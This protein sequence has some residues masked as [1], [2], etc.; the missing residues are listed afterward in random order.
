MGRTPDR[1]QLSNA[2]AGC[3]VTAYFI[4]L[5]GKSKGC[6]RSKRDLSTKYLLC[7]SIF[8]LGKR[9]KKTQFKYF[10]IYME[11]ILHMLQ[12]YLYTYIYIQFIH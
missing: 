10:F 1:P 7:Y 4:T 9:I 8:W 3:V 6:V 11:Y 12:Q 5:P 2:V